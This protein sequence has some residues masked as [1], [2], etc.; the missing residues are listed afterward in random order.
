M[1]SLVKFGASWCGPCKV[2]KETIKQLIS[3]NPSIDCVEVDIDDEPGQASDLH[4]R[5]IPTTIIYKDN[6]EVER[7]TGAVS[8]HT[9]KQAIK[10]Y[11]G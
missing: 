9:L 3:S 4:I 8:L 10:K 11:N 1:I 6:E 7:L 5:T 2:M